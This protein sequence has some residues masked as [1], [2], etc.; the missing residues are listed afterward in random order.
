MSLDQQRAILHTPNSGPDQDATLTAANL[1]SLTATITDKDGDTTSDSINIGTALHFHDDAPAAIVANAVHAPI[2]LDETRPVGTETD[3]N[4]APAGLV[5]VTAAFASNFAAP[6]YGSDGAGL[7]AATFSLLLTGTNVNSGLY[8]LDPLDTTASDGDGI[9]RGAQ[10]VLNQSGN[11]ITGSLGVTPYFTISIN[12][13]T[14]DVTFAQSAN[15]WHANTGSDDDASTLTLAAANLLQVV[16]TVTDADG[17]TGFAAVNVGTG[18]FQIEDDGP[19]AANIT[20]TINEGAAPITGNLLTDGPGSFGTDSGYVKSVTANATTYT[21]NPATDA[22]TFAGGPN[23]GSFNSATNVLTIALTSGASF[24]IDIDNGSYSYTAPPAVGANI[25]EPFGF[26]LADRDGDTQS[27]TLTVNVNNVDQAPIVANDHVIT[28]YESLIG[29][30]IDPD[31]IVIPHYALLHNDTDPDGQAISVTAAVVTSDFASV[32]FNS[33]PGSVTATE[34][35][36]T[37]IDGGT[38]T[39]TGTAGALSDTGLVTVSR[40]S[41]SPGLLTGT[42]SGEILLGNSGADTLRGGGG[43]DVLIGRGGD[44]IF[45]FNSLSDSPTLAQADLIGDFEGAFFFGGDIIDLR[46]IDANTAVLNNQAFTF[47]DVATSNVFAHKVTWFQDVA[48]NRTIIQADVNG[49]TTADLVITIRGLHIL[50]GF[51]FF[52]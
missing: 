48:N 8:A 1:I 10:I 50:S 43:S 34:E 20:R 41:T 9:G 36:D 14:G 51:D 30:G 44:D 49:N 4:S 17:D 42:G 39:Y 23:N 47:V 11:T 18:V 37:A 26:T 24:T 6:N 32:S 35:S 52:L 28:N 25:S 45:D 40:P 29:P 19:T 38:F 27:A 13:N 3:G 31:Q 16:Q 15:I 33:P 21:Y 22:I 2:V 5:S 12:P 7:G 46:T